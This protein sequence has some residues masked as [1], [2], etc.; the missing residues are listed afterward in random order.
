MTL[1][2]AAMDLHVPVAEYA[3]TTSVEICVT[4]VCTVDRRPM[5]ADLT[6]TAYPWKRTAPQ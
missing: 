3:L 6:A 1:T 2:D 4:T 5:D